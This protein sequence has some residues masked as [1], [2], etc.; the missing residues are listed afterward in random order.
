MAD[1]VS[2]H[3]RKRDNALIMTIIPREFPSINPGHKMKSTFISLRCGKE[4]N[5]LED[6]ASN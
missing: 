3:K 5:Y 6:K 2:Q 4:K 1:G